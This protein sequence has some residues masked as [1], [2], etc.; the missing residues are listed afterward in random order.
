MSDVNR[1]SRLLQGDAITV[2][3][4]PSLSFLL[5]HLVKPHPREAQPP[6]G[7]VSLHTRFLSPLA[8][9]CNTVME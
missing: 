2:K 8:P 4:A 1:G 5:L 9:V 6:R 7:M 3:S